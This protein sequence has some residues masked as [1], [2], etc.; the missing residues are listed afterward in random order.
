ML[1]H[2]L[3]NVPSTDTRPGP[4][5]VIEK[6]PASHA[7]S[8]L[9]HSLC[10][11]SQTSPARLSTAAS[12]QAEA[13]MQSSCARAKLTPWYALSMERATPT[14]AASFAQA[15]QTRACHSPKGS[16]RLGVCPGGAGGGSYGDPTRMERTDVC[17]LPIWRAASRVLLAPSTNTALLYAPW[18]SHSR[19]ISVPLSSCDAKS[20]LT[21]RSNGTGMAQ[22]ISSW[23]RS[24]QNQ[25]QHGSWHSCEEYIQNDAMSMREPP[26]A[27]Y[28]AFATLCGVRGC[29]GGAHLVRTSCANGYEDEASPYSG[30]SPI[31]TRAARGC[32]LR[33]SQPCRSIAR[34]FKASV[35][36]SAICTR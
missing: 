33:C 19:L 17:W 35:C 10:K 2:A 9:D 23:F 20:S 4:S 18:I 31:H 27:V 6:V 15:T 12:G 24:L 7:A 1:A 25:S 5:L 8:Q 26:L 22:W 28:C 14:G 29:P 16:A 11:R 13:R 3:S 30:S 36:G 34:M 32:Q 21:T